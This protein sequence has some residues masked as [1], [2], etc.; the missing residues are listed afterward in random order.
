MLF[1]SSI[2]VTN[3]NNAAGIPPSVVNPLRVPDT[4][5]VKTFVLSLLSPLF[6]YPFI[7]KIEKKIMIIQTDK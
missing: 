2:Q 1:R 7:N 5:P 4:I 3:K 6:V